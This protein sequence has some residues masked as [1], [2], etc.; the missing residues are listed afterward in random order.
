M[1]AKKQQTVYTYFA[2]QNPRTYQSEIL[3]LLQWQEAW[4][5]AGYSPVV[6]KLVNVHTAHDYEAWRTALVMKHGEDAN[7]YQYD[8]WKA[9]A[10]TVRLSDRA[11]F[12]DYNVFPTAKWVEPNAWPNGLTSMHA[13]N[14]D[15]VCATGT[16]FNQ[17]AKE[18]VNHPPV[19]GAELSAVIHKMFAGGQGVSVLC[20]MSI[21][22]DTTGQLIRFD[23]DGNVPAYQLV[24]QYQK[25]NQQ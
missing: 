19:Q 12:V 10:S 24:D 21:Y 23:R 25:G 6:L 13:T 14:E 1:A 8:R 9:I 7:F 15:A 16:V 17:I 4:A 22:P 3:L 2:F 20:A 18:L 11:L 5:K